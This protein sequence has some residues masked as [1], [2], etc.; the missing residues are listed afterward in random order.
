MVA[1]RFMSPSTHPR[2]SAATTRPGFRRR[3]PS[4]CSWRCSWFSGS[5]PPRAKRPLTEA[6]G[7][8]ANA[9]IAILALLGATAGEAVVW[10]G[11]QFYALFFLTQTLKVAAT[12]SAIMIAIALALGTPFFIVF[13][14]L[15]DKIGR[16]PII[17]AGF[18]LAAVTYFPIFQGI[19]HYAN[20]ALEAALAA[21]PVTVVADPAKCSFQLKLTN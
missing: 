3:Q 20:P 19:T 12:T 2:T 15:S 16:K 17:M 9:K 6:F 14:W 5:A 4:D 11:G 21:S 1:Q 10:Y 13:G 18:L 8:W 7:N